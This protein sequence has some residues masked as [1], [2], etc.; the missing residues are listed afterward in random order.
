MTDENPYQSPNDVS[1]ALPLAAV[2]TDDYGPFVGPAAF[3]LIGSLLIMISAGPVL[4]TAGVG[5][6][7]GKASAWE[8]FAAAASVFLTASLVQFAGHAMLN[9]R[10]RLVVVFTS[11]LGLFTCLFAP[12]FAVILFRLSKPDVWNS[13]R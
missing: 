12:V 11:I 13:F 6:A 5:I 2:S 3:C 4:I 9:R 10:H 8:I 7:L 1:E